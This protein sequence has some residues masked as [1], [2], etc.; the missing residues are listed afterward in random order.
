[1]NEKGERQK[2][3]AQWEDACQYAHG[4]NIRRFPLATAALLITA[5]DKLAQALQE[6]HE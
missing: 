1:M 4:G 2:L 6:S 3:L 5:G